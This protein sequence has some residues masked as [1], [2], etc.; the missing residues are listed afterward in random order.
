[1]NPIF[2]YLSL[3]AKYGAEPR[4]WPRSALYLLKTFAWEP[5]RYAE[6][7]ER[8]LS[9]EPQVLPHAPV[10][11]LG[12]YRSG[13]THLQETLIQDPRLGYMNFFQGFFPAA[14]QHVEKPLKPVCERIVKAIGLIHPAHDIPFSFDLPAEEDVAMVA[15]GSKLAANWGQCLPHSFKEIYTR[16]GLLEGIDPAELQALRDQQND[17]FY[18]V[19]KANGHKQLV[20]KSPPQLGRV[21]MLRAMYPNAKFVFIRRNT[22][23]VFASNKKLWRSFSKTW[24]QDIGPEEVQENILWSYD[25]CHAA[26]ERDKTEIPAA[27]LCE[28]SFEDFRRAPVSTL[29]RVYEDLDLGDF[30]VV[31]PIF[32]AYLARTHQSVQPPYRLREDE[33]QAIDQRLGH[34]LDRWGYRRDAGQP[35]PSTAEPSAVAV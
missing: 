30:R 22:Y 26:Y 27:Q 24:L 1:M 35:S 6:L 7:L 16:L 25:R 23:E 29:R 31:E 3:L 33:L 9:N 10:F 8:K 4:Y 5:V 18:R 32:E 15:W 14:F 19:S 20:L 21:A 2:S 17:L 12:Y 13:T 34:W 11:I 28:I